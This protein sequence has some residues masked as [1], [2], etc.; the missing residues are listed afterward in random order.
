MIGV[1][2]AIFIGGLCILWFSSAYWPAVFEDQTRKAGAA[3][4]P[5]LPADQQKPS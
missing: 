2:L 3:E 1:L 5:K 4:P